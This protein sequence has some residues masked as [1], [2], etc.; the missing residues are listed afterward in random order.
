MSWIEDELRA[1]FPRLEPPPGFAERVLAR[2]MPVRRSRLAYWQFLPIAAALIVALAVGLIQHERHL[3]SEREAQVAKRQLLFAV[4]LAAGKL[5]YATAKAFAVGADRKQES[6]QN[7][8]GDK[9]RQ[10]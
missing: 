10:L 6:R 4:E 1:S 5:H 8:E 7:S 2:T 3:R 9:G